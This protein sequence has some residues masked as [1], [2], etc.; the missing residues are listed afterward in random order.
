MIILE[1]T[2]KAK[3]AENS[4][5]NSAFVSSLDDNAASTT[6]TQQHNNRNNNGVG[7]GGGR[8]RGRSN[9]RGG[10]R[11]QL[12][13]Y[14]WPQYPYQQPQWTTPTYPRQQ[15]QWAY[16]WQPWATPPCPYPTTVSPHQQ[17]GI[18]GP[19]PQQAHMA[20]APPHMNSQQGLLQQSG[21]G[22]R[23]KITHEELHDYLDLLL[24]GSFH[25]MLQQFGPDACRHEMVCGICFD[26]SVLLLPCY[27]QACRP[28]NCR[29]HWF[30][31]ARLLMLHVAMSVVALMRVQCRMVGCS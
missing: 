25:G 1:E 28:D 20:T 21:P 29:L 23:C 26:D 27:R 31:A 8:G 19:K 10:G 7:R 15:Q 24:L 5:S 18:L 2:A 14:Q 11:S 16:P 4:S 6:L 9:G 3:K 30:I 12:Q 13:P 17:S 22:V